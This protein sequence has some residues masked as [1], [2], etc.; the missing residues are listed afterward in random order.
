MESTID[1]HIDARMEESERRMKTMT[2]ETKKMVEEAKALMGRA[3]PNRQSA[4]EVSGETSM[5]GPW[6]P[7][8]LEKKGVC[9]FADRFRLGVSSEYVADFTEKL[10][11]KME[12][13]S[14]QYIDWDRTEGANR[15]TFFFKIVLVRRENTDRETVYTV[16][17]EISEILKG[18]DM[19]IRHSLCYCAAQASPLRR[20]MYAAGGRYSNA[21]ESL[22]DA[23]VKARREYSG[24]E[25][26]ILASGP[27]GT[28]KNTH[29]QSWVGEWSSRSRTWRHFDKELK[30][31]GVDRAALEAK[32]QEE[33]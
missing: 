31:V 26:T 28:D 33:S 6:Q 3:G 7:K 13:E 12:E 22:C 15:Y 8:T 11:D 17:G 30:V 25:V 19:R 32:L 10:K 27:E 24:Q 18:D 2:A 16:K 14:A 23:S 5:G 29:L 21:F 20:E 1:E 9:S 4:S